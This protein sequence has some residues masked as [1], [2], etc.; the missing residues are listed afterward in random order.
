MKHKTSLTKKK[1]RCLTTA[2]LGRKGH[3]QTKS[4]EIYRERERE[5]E[6]ITPGVTLKSYTFFKPLD[7]S[8][9]NG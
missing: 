9:S 3:H 4:N 1:K 5:R 7:L 6:R 2:I 8:I